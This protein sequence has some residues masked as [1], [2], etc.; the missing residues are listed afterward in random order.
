MDVSSEG[1]QESSGQARSYPGVCNR[2]ALWGPRPLTPHSL[3]PACSNGGDNGDPQNKVGARR[4]DGGSRQ[5]VSTGMCCPPSCMVP[6]RRGLSGLGAG[7]APAL[8]LE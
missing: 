3:V 8:A 1:V 2:R 4:N 6:D 7:C 5:A